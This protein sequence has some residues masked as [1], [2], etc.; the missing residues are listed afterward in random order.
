[1]QGAYD[2]QFAPRWVVGGFVDADWSNV[3][4]HAKQAEDSSIAFACDNPGNCENQP[5]GSF[6][7]SNGTID[8]KVS[9]DWNISVGGRIG[10]L[11]NQGTLLYLL[12]AYTHADLSDAQVKVSIPDPS[13]LVGVLLGGP[14]GSSPFPTSNTSLLVKLPDS[15]D[16][17]SLG[18][19]AEAKLGGPWSLKLEYRWTHLEGGSGRANSDVS[20]CCF[21]GRDSGGN[22][23]F[24]NINSNASANFDADEQTV[25]G[26]LAY[27][28]WSGG[29]GG[30]GG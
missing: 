5:L 8:T 6:A 10:W 15:L 18:G 21:E 1:M 20:Q 12:A 3:S 22:Q 9:T 14:P 13:D 23:L 19:G 7:P 28:F 25:R 30:Y 27:H 24:R 29:N 11:A 16:G 17:W 4:G 2:Y 26:A